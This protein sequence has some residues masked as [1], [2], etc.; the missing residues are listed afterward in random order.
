MV[1][2]EEIVRRGFATKIDW[3]QTGFDFLPPC[4]NG[5]DAIAAIDELRPDVVMTD[6]HMPHADGLAVANHVMER[7]P[8]I[9]VVILSGYDEFDYAQAAIRAKVFDYVLKPVSSRDLAALL[10]KLKDKLDAD[11]RS[12]EDEVALKAKAGLSGGLLRERDFSAFVEGGPLPASAESVLGFD[13]GTMACAAIVAELDGLDTPERSTGEPSTGEP[14]PGLRERL[15][16]AL[17]QARRSAAACPA[18]GRAIALIFER[19][20]ER[21]GAVAAA[22]ASALAADGGPPL[23]VGVGRAY[24]RWADAPRA[25]SEAVAALSYRL[26]REAARPFVYAQGREG[27]EVLEALKA[28]EERILLALRTGAD[29]RMDELTRAFVEALGSAELSPQRVRHEVIALFSRGR[30]ELSGIGVSSP[31]LSTKLAC[32]YYSF[33]ER[34]D[35][36]EAIAAALRRLC[37]I[38]AE[39]LETSS[40]HTPA[41]KVLDFKEYVARH[42]ADKGLSIGKVA[43]RLS[44]SESYLSKL[45]R[46]R[47]GQSFVDYVS[48]YR[49]E[50]A[51]ELIAASDMMAYEV[52]EAVGYP[53]ARYFS[54]IFKKRTGL[55]LSEY[56]KSLGGASGRAGGEAS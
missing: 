21:C 51:K 1:D 38:A 40:L 10:A 28:C 31:T 52:A 19:G 5:R 13:P 22:V 15:G 2:D 44:I 36:P 8:G 26:V 4:V 34:L 25:Y 12:R 50:R 23:R 33:A 37:E 27:R 30:D 54:S 11:R 9:V 32:D 53:D 20:L 39:A 47:L 48:D 42:Y 41:W 29:G 17:A 49:V 43:E 7:H 35:R 6:I 16:S 24:E 46:R 14:S 18:E 3:A 56:R 55:T 45:L